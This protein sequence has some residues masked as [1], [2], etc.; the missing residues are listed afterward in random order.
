MRDEV[1]RHRRGFSKGDCGRALLSLMNAWTSDLSFA[2]V[3]R[4]AVAV[5]GAPAHGDEGRVRRRAHNESKILV[6]PRIAVQ[7]AN[8]RTRRAYQVAGLFCVLS[9]FCV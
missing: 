4:R 5:A 7:R 6:T 2:S 1:I 3:I 9:E 8:R